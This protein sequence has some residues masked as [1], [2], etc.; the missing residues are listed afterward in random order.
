MY[1]RTYMTLKK[2]ENKREDMGKRQHTVKS[3]KQELNKPFNCMY[4]HE[5]ISFFFY[6]YNV[7]L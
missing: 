3:S 6:V 5:K 4:M 2:I 1:T 7:H